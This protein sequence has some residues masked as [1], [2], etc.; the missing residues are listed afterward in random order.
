[1]SVGEIS[2]PLR[3]PVHVRGQHVGVAPEKS[4][5]VVQIVDTDHQNIRR[6]LYWVGADRFAGWLRFS[7]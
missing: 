5:P 3:Q 2:A 7:S 4:R 1:M 6:I